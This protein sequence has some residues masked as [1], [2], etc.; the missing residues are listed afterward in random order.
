[1]GATIGLSA[2]ILIAGLIGFLFWRQRKIFDD[3]GQFYKDNNLFYRETSPVE[4]PFIYTDIRPICS[5]GHL[6]PDMP[7]TFI[8]GSRSEGAGQTRILHTYIGVFIPD[9]PKLSDIWLS[10]WQKKVAERGDNWAKHSGM[11]PIEKNW[12]LM[13]APEDLPIVAMRI[14]NG[15]LISWIG[16]H[17]R[18]TFETR[19]DELKATL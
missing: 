5:Q 19:L 6:L 11:E 7:F 10:S 2:L 3:I 8:L 13:G 18:K 15:I 17:I 1:M 9:H 14:N 4:H 16:L 12:G